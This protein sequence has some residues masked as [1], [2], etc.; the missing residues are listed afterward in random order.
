MTLE[1]IL[2][3][4]KMFSHFTKC[5]TLRKMFRISINVH[6]I[7]NKKPTNEKDKMGNHRKKKTKEMK[8]T[9]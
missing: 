1:S 3:F 8:K 9:E 7:K 2:K 4:N 5:S 6:E